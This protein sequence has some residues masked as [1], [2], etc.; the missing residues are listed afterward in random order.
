MSSLLQSATDYEALLRVRDPR[1]P[2]RFDRIFQAEGLWARRLAR[3]RLELLRRLE[4]DL[5]RMLEPGEQVEYVSWGIEYSFVEAYFLGIWH[6]L[7]NRRA[8]V[9][10]DRRILLLQID[11]RRRLRDLKYQVRLDAIRRFAR[12]SFGYLC[13][14]LHGKKKVVLTGLPRADRKALRARIEERLQ[15][16]AGAQRPA[17][18]G[19][20]Q[21]LCPHCY[22]PVQ[23]LPEQCGACRGAF[24]SGARAGWLSLAL[25]GLGDLYLGH[26]LLGVF[27]IL[28][29]LCAWAL[30][31]TAL[32]PVQPEEPA[33]TGALLLVSAF[34]FAA[35]HGVDGLITRHTG[36]KGLYPAR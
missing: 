23:G 11:S 29:A 34:V 7:L 15:P 33:G 36:R 28:G 32:W 10:T 22:R 3:R 6:Y 24:K 16:D 13:F 25:P 20:K 8:V 4:A 1:L 31:L 27:E 5:A 30:V 17:D 35:V 14:E 18:G 26:H 19:G 12:R 2:Y 9:L 21:N